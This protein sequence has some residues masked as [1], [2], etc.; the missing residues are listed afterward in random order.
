MNARDHVVVHVV[1][2]LIV[3]ESN[4]LNRVTDAGAKGNASTRHWDT[5]HARCLGWHDSHARS[6]QMAQPGSLLVH[7][8]VSALSKWGLHVVPIACLCGQ[9]ARRMM[10][11]KAPR[12][13]LSQH[14]PIELWA[15]NAVQ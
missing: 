12:A 1:R 14:A 8:I 5:H 6:L 7:D 13:V 15:A 3:D 9:M 11:S 4:M 10:A 2:G